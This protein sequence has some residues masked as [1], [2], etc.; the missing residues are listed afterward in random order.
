MRRDLNIRL[1]LM[2]HQSCFIFA[3]SGFARSG[4]GLKCP[5]LSHKDTKGSKWSITFNLSN[6]CAFVIW[7][8]IITLNAYQKSAPSYITELRFVK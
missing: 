7:W 1:L 5:P 3:E 8:L 6:F 2:Y 4:P